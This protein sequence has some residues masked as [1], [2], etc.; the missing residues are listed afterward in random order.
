MSYGDFYADDI[1]DTA[2]AATTKQLNYIAAWAQIHTLLLGSQDLR[3]RFIRYLDAMANAHANAWAENFDA[4]AEQA[5]EAQYRDLVTLSTIQRGK[6]PAPPLLAH[7]R[8]ARLMHAAEVHWLWA[9][10]RD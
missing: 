2:E 10:L 3:E 4:A 8:P 1:P 5:L 7:E 6:L 9:T